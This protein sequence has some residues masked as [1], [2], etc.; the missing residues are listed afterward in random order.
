MKSLKRIFLTLIICCLTIFGCSCSKEKVLKREEAITILKEIEVDKNVKIVTTT[1]TNINNVNSLSL[2]TDIYYN[3]TYYHLSDSNNVS[4]KTW[5]GT[6]DNVLYAFYYTKNA[7]NE[8]TKTSSRID[9]AL[10]QSA[11][12][13]PSS[14]I[15][16]LFKNDNELIDNTQIEAKRKGS[17]YT[18]NVNTTLENENNNYVITIK[19]DKILKI[20][21]TN[22][23][24]DDTITTT[25]DY[26]YNIDPVELPSLNEYPLT[27]NG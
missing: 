6:V 1:S 9:S 11:Q 4:T 26:S 18:I 20:V 5:Y 24:L 21:T 3:D 23:I 14:V 8:E 25:Y 22:T 2:Q 13:Q 19:D 10:L 15:K 12:K 17:T 7:N 16:S 27:V